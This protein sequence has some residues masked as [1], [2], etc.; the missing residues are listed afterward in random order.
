[1]SDQTV[2]LITIH[3]TA[4]ERDGLTIGIDSPFDG[5]VVDALNRIPWA[6][7]YWQKEKRIYWVAG[8]HLERVKAICLEG[9]STVWLI[10]GQRRTE[11]RTGATHEQLDL[12]GGVTP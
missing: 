8:R 11:L 5:G 1:M 12:F 9:Y 6:D 7:R 10:D 3:A 2:C 4:P